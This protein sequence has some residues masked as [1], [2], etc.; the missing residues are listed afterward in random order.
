MVSQ[1][2]PDRADLPQRARGVD[3]GGPDAAQDVVRADVDRHVGDVPEL[4]CRNGTASA[5]LVTSG[6]P[7]WRR[8]RRR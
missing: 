8:G 4:A 1:V 3:A 6:V 2:G 7:A 5:K